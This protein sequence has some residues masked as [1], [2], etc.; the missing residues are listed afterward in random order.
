MAPIV[1]LFLRTIIVIL[2][3][4]AFLNIESGIPAFSS[5]KGVC[6]IF[7]L[8][9]SGSI[10][11]GEREYAKGL[12]K[13]YKD[14]MSGKDMA[15]LVIFGKDPLVEWQ[16][17]RASSLPSQIQ[18]R[19]AP[20]ESE[21]NIYDALTLA[22][23]LFPDGYEKH[24]VLLSDGVQTGDKSGIEKI[25]SSLNREG[26]I[27]HTFPLKIKRTSG[28]F[29]S[30]VHLPEATH[31][32]TSFPIRIVI[33]GKGEGEIIIYQNGTV[34][35]K[36]SISKTSQ[37][38]EVMTYSSNEK[39]P[40]FSHYDI[41]LISGSGKYPVIQKKS[42]IV[43]V[44]GLLKVLYIKDPNSNAKP[45]ISNIISSQG[46]PLEYI[47]PAGLESD[48]KDH[49]FKWTQ[50]GL[51]VI[52][53]IPAS[54]ISPLMMKGIHDY[55]HDL[56][57]GL[58][59]IGGKNA[60]GPGGYSET[61]IEKASP[62]FMRVPTGSQVT[63]MDMV[64]LLDKSG[65]MDEEI[66]GK[67]K[68]ETTINAAV[69]ILKEIRKGDSLGIIAFDSETHE[70]VSLKESIDSEGALSRLKNIVPA[71]ATDIYNALDKAA[72]ELNVQGK[73]VQ[74]QHQRLRHIIILSDGKAKE[75]D[76]PAMTRRLKEKGIS[77]SAVSVGTSEEGVILRDL[78]SSTG[79]QFYEVDKKDLTTEK[80]SM[81]FKRDT[82]MA[83]N[84]WFVTESFKPVLKYTNSGIEKG[85]VLY[86]NALPVLNGYVR[87]SPKNSASV[88]IE[89]KYGEPLIALWNYGS[90]R[91]I[92]FTS[93]GSGV[94]SGSW[95]KWPLF[96]GLVGNM[97]RWG[98]MSQD[99]YPLNRYRTT[100]KKGKKGAITA[101]VKEY[102]PASADYHSLKK[103]TDLTGGRILSDND[104]PFEEEDDKRDT[105]EAWLFYLTAIVVIYILDV[106]VYKGI[107]L[108]ILKRRRGN[109]L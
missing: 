73:K 97:V 84:R 51:I 81:I 32:N 44:E 4:L 7:V 29:L 67:N 86:K 54:D 22:S 69:T 109:V 66:K 102:T 12:I 65:S 40:G 52:D 37:G 9:H 34:K 104:N 94:W 21:T 8:D 43:R 59:M 63:G 27:V 107:P 2:F 24:I 79:G 47:T 96:H 35:Y 58:L 10:S 25:A 50:Y 33:E 36:K 71:G 92:A 20:A 53:N 57:G 76:F 16:P 93:D 46:I 105:G 98:M 89:S 3:I 108:L 88:L 75:A 106:A 11:S 103:I 28:I 19:S 95:L 80:L 72:D 78:A 70:I 1:S 23:S 56:G 31:P 49:A 48:F 62:V 101:E 61:L 87:T 45:L 64:L 13:R 6:T 55:V 18:F 74:L 100:I 90:G 30:N 60:F 42:G 82:V 85:L 5:N 26:I 68:W 91:T 83:S 15:G 39:S 77:V 17:A 14:R 41:E 38:S 99:M